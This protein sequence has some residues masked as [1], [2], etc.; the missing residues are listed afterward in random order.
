MR[1]HYEEAPA[2]QF[3]E[4]RPPRHSGL[5]WIRPLSP[6]AN[7]GCVR[8]VALLT[9][10]QYTHQGLHQYYLSLYRPSSS[11]RA[12]VPEADAPPWKRLLLTTPRPRRISYQVDV[13]TRESS[14]F[15]TRHHDAQKDRAAVRAMINQGVTA[16][17]AARDANRN[18]DDS[19][20]SGTGGRRAEHVVR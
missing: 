20:T 17:L 8:D 18:G 13:C 15:C 5:H 4:D 3:F 11:R 7:R 1:I 14:E 16:A 2:Q 19:H 6:R 9:I 10:I 12:D